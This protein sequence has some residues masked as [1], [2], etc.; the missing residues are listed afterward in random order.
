MDRKMKIL[1]IS[2]Y[3][4]PEVNA[5][6]LRVS[7]LSK[8]WA[9]QGHEITVLTGFPNH[10][11]GI[12]PNEYKG[13]I[14]AKEIH[15]NVKVVRTYV[16][17]AANKGFVKRILNYLSFMFSSI[18]LGMRAVGKSD[19]LIA[20]SPQFFVA[21]A[22]YVIS[23]IKRCKFIFEVR[24]LWPEEIVAVGAIKNKLII[25]LLEQIEM[26]LYRRADLVVAVAQGT[27]DTLVKRGIPQNKLV[28]IPNGVEIEHFQNRNGYVK[29]ALGF[30]NKFVASYIGTHGMAHR[31]ET[32]LE[33][34]ELLREN[35]RIQFLLVG[36]G[37]EKKRLVNR[38]KELKLNNVMFH[39]QIDRNRIPEFYNASD[40]FLVPLR[41]A[42]LFTRNIPSKIYEIMAAKKPMII[43]TEGESRK[44]VE[45]SG[46][47]I[48]VSPENS[49]ELADQI[50]YLFQNP[51]LC[52]EMGE[53][54]FAF[55][56][57]NASR[58][59]LADRYLDV[60][61][62]LVLESS[63]TSKLILKRGSEFVLESEEKSRVRKFVEN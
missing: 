31:L 28:L 19:I 5:P 42:D 46:A 53:S 23:R 6:A 17:A 15:G 50:T 9:E 33:A 16:Y 59:S 58:S 41:K 56:L 25:R 30:E 48:G 29:K 26:F 57:A 52:R 39:D 4:P 13:L 27:I 44:L 7:E 47:G 32:V 51:E 38:A 40:L 36:D 43:S 37:A 8:H 61:E 18:L 14:R 22:G 12:I 24:D 49:R 34:A 35:D 45:Q 54:G 20:T 55:A 2:H 11:S 62:K 60:L 21:V 1:Y 10:P 3:Y 63:T